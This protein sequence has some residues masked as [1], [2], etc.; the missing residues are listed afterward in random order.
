MIEGHGESEVFCPVE[1][2]SLQLAFIYE[3]T[4]FF[5]VYSWFYSSSLWNL[6]NF[7]FKKF[8]HFLVSSYIMSEWW[9]SFIWSLGAVPNLPFLYR[10]QVIA[11]QQNFHEILWGYFIFLS[12]TLL[13][14][15]ARVKRALKINLLINSSLLTVPFLNS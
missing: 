7:I 4:I 1:H 14:W 2:S 3:D 12:K 10:S 8:H 9:N 5:A 15:N 13:E 11:L 6:S